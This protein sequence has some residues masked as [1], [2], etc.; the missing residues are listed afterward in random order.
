MPQQ[1]IN[2]GTAANT[3]TGEPLRDA[4]IKINGNT[5]ET[6][7]RIG[8]PAQARSYIG[9]PRIDV[10]AT[11]GGFFDAG[12]HPLGNIFSDLGSAQAAYPNAGITTL[13]DETDWAAMQQAIYD[14]ANSAGGLIGLHSGAQMIFG[15]KSL[16]IIA[17]SK[18]F[19]R[20]GP[21]VGFRTANLPAGVPA[22]ILRGILANEHKTALEDISFYARNTGSAGFTPIENNG[23]GHTQYTPGAI[24]MSV[25]D[26]SG[27]SLHRVMFNCYDTPFINGNN[28]WGLL[29]DKC[30]FCNNNYGSRWARTPD[31]NTGEQ[32]KWLNCSLSNNNWGAYLEP[33]VLDAYGG[34]SLGGSF[35]IEGCSLDYNQ[36]GQIYYD[37]GANGFNT[38]NILTILGGHME[39]NSAVSGPNCRIRMKG[40]MLS[41]HGTFILENGGP[42]TTP[43][44]VEING[45]SRGSAY[46][47]LT[48]G[49]KEVWPVFWAP[50]G[51]PKTYIVSGSGNRQPDGQVS[52]ILGSADDGYVVD[53]SD[54]AGYLPLNYGDT[55]GTL[56]LQGPTGVM[57]LGGTQGGTLTI[58]AD[59]TIKLMNGVTYEFLTTDRAFSPSPGPPASL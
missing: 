52:Y 30:I 9:I 18:V 36:V 25:Y 53:Q 10:K 37:G 55:G 24:A 15:T 56:S 57:T 26:C 46:G 43:G 31:Y 11:Y 28:L 17:G 58:P 14:A 16:D 1:I 44:L 27:V 40:G 39:T 50:A 35:F 48:K 41:M 8:T 20:G 22:L 2:V 34:A 4:F 29:F 33:H 23:L 12:S 54:R 51:V 7:N 59:S 49:G 13:A 42:N 3:G 32:I 47:V 45:N 21:S 5:T 6:Y 38:T 19:L